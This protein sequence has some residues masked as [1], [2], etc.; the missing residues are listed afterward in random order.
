[1]NFKDE[2]A[3]STFAEVTGMIIRRWKILD[4]FG[5]DRELSDFVEQAAGNKYIVIL[6]LSLACTS[7][8]QRST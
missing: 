2:L 7:I 8:L 6:A 5:Y 1:M 3:R 4:K